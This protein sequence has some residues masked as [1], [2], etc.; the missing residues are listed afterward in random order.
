M[1]W[2]PALQP[3][4]FSDSNSALLSSFMSSHYFLYFSGSSNF[5]LAVAVEYLLTLPVLPSEILHARFSWQNITGSS[6]I[7]KPQT[8]AALNLQEYTLN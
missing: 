5:L 6:T 3:H 2:L 8:P 7:S 4:S 1:Q